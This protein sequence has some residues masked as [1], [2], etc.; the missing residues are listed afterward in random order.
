MRV[1]GIALVLVTAALAADPASAQYQVPPKEIVDILDAPPLPTAAVSPSRQVM[2]LLERP[3]MPPIADLAQPM[4][5]LA[6]LRINPRT[7]GPHR[8]QYAV[9]VTP[10]RVSYW[11]GIKND[12]P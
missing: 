8:F 2:A 12:F 10:Y 1:S 7:N 11:F 5:R 9:A 4:L 6:G 3:S